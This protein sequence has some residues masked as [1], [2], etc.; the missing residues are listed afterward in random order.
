VVRPRGPRGYLAE[1]VARLNEGVNEVLQRPEIIEALENQGF[2][3]QLMTPE[4]FRAYQIA[5]FE[6]FGPVAVEASQE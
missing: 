2:I 5:Q 6:L 1:V 4:E 3:V